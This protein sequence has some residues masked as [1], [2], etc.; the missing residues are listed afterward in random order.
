MIVPGLIDVF[1]RDFS[2]INILVGR[3]PRKDFSFKNFKTFGYIKFT[4]CIIQYFFHQLINN[5]L[6]YL[7]YEILTQLLEYVR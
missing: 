2:G 3:W 4:E 6:E 7:K 1:F 5:E